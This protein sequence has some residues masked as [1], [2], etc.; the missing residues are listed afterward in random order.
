MCKLRVTI[1]YLEGVISF[2]QKT[3]I[4]SIDNNVQNTQ[5]FRKF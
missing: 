2:M 5:R 1:D 3:K 4:Y